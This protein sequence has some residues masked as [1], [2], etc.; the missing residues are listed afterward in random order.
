MTPARHQRPAGKTIV[1]PDMI[2]GRDWGRGQMPA[3]KVSVVAQVFFG[4][5]SSWL[6]RHIS[7]KNVFIDQ[8]GKPI[9]FRRLDPAKADSARVFLLSDVEQM[10]LRLYEIG[11][12]DAAKLSRVLAVVTAQAD[13]FRLFDDPGDP[14]PERVPEPAGV[15]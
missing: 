5:S 14:A 9:D 12:I 8:A 15:A 10:A 6:R 2:L 1:T 4:M 13:L 11:G 7:Q 3:Y